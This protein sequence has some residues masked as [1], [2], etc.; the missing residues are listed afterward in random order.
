MTL[1]YALSD[2]SSI[3]KQNIANK[4]FSDAQILFWILCYADRLKSQHIPK[5]DSGAFIHQ[6]FQIQVHIDT[7]TGRQYIELPV[8]IYDF[9]LDD[10]IN[11]L[12]YDYT[13]DECSPPFTSVTFA[14]TTP[15]KSAR[16][17][18]TDEE[19]PTPDNPYFYRIGDRLY[20]LGT[21]CITILNLEG[22]FYSSFDPTTTC[23]LDDEFDFPVELYPILQR[24][25]LDLARF[26]L[27]IPYDKT[28]TGNYNL[29]EDL[30]S[31]PKNKLVSVSQATQDTNAATQE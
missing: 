7:I 10:G 29:D 13:V 5:I 1:R 9:D 3:L 14:R 4:K 19:K 25:I 23:D 28:N 24:Q 17:Y 20:L 26:G 18:W 15:S 11:Y 30:N 27:A 22:G 12:S 16:L 31:V 2:I 21:Q 8:G 6:Y